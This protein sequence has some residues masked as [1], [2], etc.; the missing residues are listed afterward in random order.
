MILKQKQGGKRKEFE[1]VG[2]NS[3]RIKEKI[4]GEEKEW[5][6]SLESIGHSLVYQS[7]TRKRAYIISA[8]LAAF[9][10]F[11]TVALFMS[12]DFYG[13]L[14]V[15]IAAYLLFGLLIGLSLLSPLKKEVHLV[16]GGASLTF[17][18]D[19]P[20]PGEVDAFIQKIIGLSKQSLLN[21][22]A[23]IDPELPEETMYNQL[24]WLK[25]RDLISEE[26][27]ADLKS[28]YKTQRLIRD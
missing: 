7:A 26:E 4:S 12:D 9:L 23:K 24:N 1:I 27:Y 15:V 19:S 18:R 17:F 14:P 20:S 3:L 25:N 28:I 11:V 6:V 22:Y 10:L 8:V 16:G 21:K 5:T 13:N 2:N